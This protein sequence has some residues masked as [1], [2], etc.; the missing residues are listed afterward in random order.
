MRI[1]YAMRLCAMCAMCGGGGNV[2]TWR[3]TEELNVSDDF[4]GLLINVTNSLNMLIMVLMVLSSLPAV[5][6]FLKNKTGTLEGKDTCQNRSG[7]LHELV[8]TW[9]LQ[10]ECKHR[11]WHPFWDSVLLQK[12]G[13]DVAARLVEL[14][15]ICRMEGKQRI[16]EHYQ[17]LQLPNVAAN[18]A[19]VQAELEGVDVFWDGVTRDGHNDSKTKFG[20]V[21]FNWEPR[22]PRGYFWAL[23]GS[24]YRVHSFLDVGETIPIHVCDGV[25]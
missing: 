20:K 8:A 24:R 12:C 7:R 25:R 10:R 17:F 1:L 3:C 16:K 23:M 14:Q 15:R 11:V 18:R 5:R 6:L 19:W 2:L 13:D 21:Q 22:V 9:D 4:M